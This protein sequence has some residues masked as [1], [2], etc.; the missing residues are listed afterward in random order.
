MPNYKVE[1]P[2]RKLSFFYEVINQDIIGRM[3]SSIAAND[4][5]IPTLVAYGFLIL[6]YLI[7][8]KVLLNILEQ[9]SDKYR[10]RKSVIDTAI[11]RTIPSD[12]DSSMQAFNIFSVAL[13]IAKWGIVTIAMA[14]IIVL[15]VIKVGIIATALL[16]AITVLLLWAMNRWLKSREK[17][18][19]AQAEVR[20]YIEKSGGVG[21]IILLSIILVVLLFLMIAIR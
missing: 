11:H 1:L 4:I 7:I 2:N 12:L 20:K 9:M 13:V 16:I 17:A 18:H 8:L 10:V 14:A 19:S 3:T 15:M 5:N 6:T 21:T